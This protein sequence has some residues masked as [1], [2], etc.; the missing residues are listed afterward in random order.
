MEALEVTPGH[1]VVQARAREHFDRHPHLRFTVTEDGAWWLPDIVDRM[2][3]KWVGGAT[4][5]NDTC[6][7]VAFK[8]NKEEMK[9][10]LSSF[11]P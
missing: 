6:F 10:F 4:G 5:I 2:D 7:L 3:E 9:E 1:A 8:G 11:A